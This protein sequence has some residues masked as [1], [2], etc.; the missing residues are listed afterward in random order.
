MTEIVLHKYGKSCCY[1]F[2][3]TKRQIL[4]QGQARVKIKYIGL[5]FTDYIIKRG[6]YKYQKEKFPLPFVQG[7]E[8]SGIIIET[9]EGE[10]SFE[11][12]DQVFGINK[13][14]CFATEICI[15]S[16][17][18][19]HKPKNYS[20][21]EIA[22]FPVNFFTAY[23]AIH[24]IVKIK[25]NS[26]ILIQSAAGGV[27]G[28]LVQIGKICGHKIIAIVSNESKVEYTKTLGSDFVFT[29]NL[30]ENLIDN[31]LKIDVIFDSYG[32]FKVNK[33]SN[34]LNQNSKIIIYGFGALLT[35]SI[36]KNIKNY[37]NLYRPKVFDLVYN[38]ITISGFNIIKF[39]ED[40]Y[41]FNQT[42]KAL[43]EALENKTILTPKI[44]TYKIEQIEEAI[45]SLTNRTN[46]GKTI[47]EI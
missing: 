30:K 47:I 5:S 17:N 38:N 29:K 34:S 46:F 35:K 10:K 32:D 16:K 41:Y 14:G 39:T 40:D 7:F 27:G 45:E 15:D 33:F 23:H 3:Q 26:N 22:S 4:K 43:I 11:V 12:G 13:F 28:M 25:P 6:Y 44:R 31:N 21:K 36:F 2:E 19:F 8:F 9:K 42:K 24:N 37:F 18:I 1:K 20:L